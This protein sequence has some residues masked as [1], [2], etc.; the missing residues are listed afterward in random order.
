M[1][2]PSVSPAILAVD[3]G[4]T[5]IAAAQVQRGHLLSQRATATPQPA[6]PEPVLR[7]VSELISPWV[8]A[9]SVLGVAA[10]GMVRDG[11][12]TAIS[13]NILRDW[14]DVPLAERLEAET[15]LPT[16]VV[17]DG[18]AAAWG[19][20][21]YGAGMDT[22]NLAYITV[23]TGVGGGLIARGNLL[24]GAS[25]LAGHLGHITV[26]SGGP[27]CSCGRKGCVE[28]MA[29]GSAIAKAASTLFG[30]PYTAEQVFAAAR[31]QEPWAL[32][33][34]QQ[35]VDYLADAI[36]TLHMVVDPGLIIIGGGVGLASGYVDLLRESLRRQP[37]ASSAKV[38]PA[39]LGAAAGQVGVADL[40]R[41]R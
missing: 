21:R 15:G 9:A 16:M 28:Q 30:M 5:K 1:S 27:W 2:N 33:I 22:E 36:A 19:E 17:N 13:R 23:S 6:E 39:A 34:I 3:I 40:A 37:A 4:G 32:G 18:Q 38:L 12:V 35:S 29:S 41:S 20:F 24:T 26:D 25:G 14:T 31:E 11:C 7:A 10:A 8:K